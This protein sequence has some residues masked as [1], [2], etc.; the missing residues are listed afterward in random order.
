MSK[1]LGSVSHC[2]LLVYIVG[3]T[4]VAWWEL[5]LVEETVC[6]KGEVVAV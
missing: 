3:R 1:H 6:A 2:D 5:K 4:W